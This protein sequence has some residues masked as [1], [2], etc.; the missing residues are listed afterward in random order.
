[1]GLSTGAAL[2]FL[3]FALPICIWAAW[4]DL[5]FMKI[6]NKAVIALLLVFAVIGL[7][8]LPLVD[9][10]WRWLHVLVV[11]V[12]GFI[13][14]IVRLI[15]AGDAKFSAAMAPFIHLAD[16]R[17]LMILFGTVLIA[18]FATHRAFR[19]MPAIR[20]RTSEWASWTAKGFPMGFALGGTLIFY[21]LLGVFYGSGS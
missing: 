4:S 17:V 1:M 7:I 15:G 8:A 10:P 13:L 12:V 20:E 6:P 21:L 2:W 18:A 3:P 11:L 5:K 9:Y 14:N 16:F 19:A